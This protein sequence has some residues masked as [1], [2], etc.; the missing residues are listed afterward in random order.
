MEKNRLDKDNLST[1]K[2]IFWSLV[3]GFFFWACLFLVIC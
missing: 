1:A 3:L 2:G